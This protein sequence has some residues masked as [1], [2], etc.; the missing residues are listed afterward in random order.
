MGAG[1]GNLG[2]LGAGHKKSMYSVESLTRVAFI[3]QERGP[4]PL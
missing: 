1:S 4:G 2:E 3:E